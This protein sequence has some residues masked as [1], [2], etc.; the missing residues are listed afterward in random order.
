MNAFGFR[1]TSAVGAAALLVAAASAAAADYPLRPVRVACLYSP[2]GGTDF[3][4]RMLA[5][6]LTAT[7]GQ[8]LAWTTVQVRRA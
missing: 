2:G 5:Q 8:P 4:A 7:L 1:F 6:R 3:T